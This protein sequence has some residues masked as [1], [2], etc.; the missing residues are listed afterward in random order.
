MDLGSMLTD[1]ET[2]VDSTPGFTAR[3]TS[4]LVLW[5]KEFQCVHLYPANT[6]ASPSL[7]PLVSPRVTSLGLGTRRDSPVHMKK[8]GSVISAT[9]L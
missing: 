1:A 5:F 4:P 8:G 2:G 6:A 3:F 9:K 7:S